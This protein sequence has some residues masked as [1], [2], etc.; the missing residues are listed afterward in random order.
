VGLPEVV[1]LAAYVAGD[2]ARLD[3]RP[4]AARA[5]EL[6]AASVAIRGT[7]DRSVPD[8]QQVADGA[9]DALGPAAYGEAYRR[10]Q[11]VTLDTLD[12]LVTPSA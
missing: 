8:D 3:G 2:L 4:D 11:R 5:A 9:R 12:A 1:A 7:H 10:G 6:L